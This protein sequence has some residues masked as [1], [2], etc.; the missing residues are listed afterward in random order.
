MADD[1]IYC[2]WASTEDPSTLKTMTNFECV[3]LSNCPAN[4]N[5]LDANG[6]WLSCYRIG[7]ACF[8]TC[9]RCSGSTSPARVCRLRPGQSCVP[10]PTPGNLVICGVNIEGE[11]SISGT[12]LGPNGCGCKFSTPPV[13][14][15]DTCSFF[16]CI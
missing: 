15:A 14:T 4:T 10:N 11:C 13:I 3:A 6:N 12:W 5:I 16:N 7:V 2:G 9:I 1:I 8:G